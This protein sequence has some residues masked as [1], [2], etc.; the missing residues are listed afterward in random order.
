MVNTTAG[1]LNT[2]VGTGVAGSAGDNGVPGDA[3]LNAP[4]KAVV[5]SVGNMFIADQ[6][7][8]AVRFVQYGTQSSHI[9]TVMQESGLAPSR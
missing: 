1:V 7:N 5:D 4:I 6:G 3:Q 8:D 2:Y 9:Y